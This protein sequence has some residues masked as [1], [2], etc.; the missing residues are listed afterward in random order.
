VTGKNGEERAER[1]RFYHWS[2]NR[3]FEDD[4]LRLFPARP[5]KAI[6]FRFRLNG[7]SLENLAGRG[8]FGKRQV[9]H[10]EAVSRAE[11]KGDLFREVA[12]KERSFLI[13]NSP[14]PS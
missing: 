12:V 4:G 6:C 9:V 2:Q 3:C 11:K 13:S 7:G 14:S 8:E 5:G 10:S 1:G